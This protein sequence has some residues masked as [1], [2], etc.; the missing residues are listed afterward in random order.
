MASGILFAG[1]GAGGLIMPFIVAGLLE[2]FGRRTTLLSLVSDLKD[3]LTQAVAFAIFLSILVPF[4]RPRLPLPAKTAR[5]SPKI[6]WA[7][8]RG[9][10]FWLLWIGVLSQGLGGFMPGTYL[11]GE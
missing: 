7:F 3:K 9:K 2:R 4:I 5:Q 8:L 6:D 10:A 11:P 1:T